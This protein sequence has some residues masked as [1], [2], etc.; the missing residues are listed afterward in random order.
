MSVHNEILIVEDSEENLIFLAQILEDHGYRFRI[1]KNG[2]EALAAMAEKRPDLVL[3]DIMM[4]R[5]S[6]I[7]VYN[8]M[9]KQSNLAGVPIIFVTG[10]SAATGV[11]IRTGEQ[12]PK[13]SY[14]DELARDLGSALYK[15]MKGLTP[16]G[17]VEKPIE[18][19]LL[20]EKIRELLP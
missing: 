6:G 10:A 9:K 8:E 7:N 14:G 13:T 5:K 3:L 4:P 19:R 2:K 1:A 15:S 18:P 17:L 11:N 20:I 16:D 12:E